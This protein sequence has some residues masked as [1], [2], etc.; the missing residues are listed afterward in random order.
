MA[1]TSVKRFLAPVWEKAAFW[2]LCKTREAQ[3]MAGF[4]GRIAHWLYQAAIYRPKGLDFLIFPN[5][6]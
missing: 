4:Q 3:G 6:A 5:V 1:D 2:A